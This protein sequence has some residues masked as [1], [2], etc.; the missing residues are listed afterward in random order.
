LK[1]EKGVRLVIDINWDL[2]PVSAA[3][4]LL[5]V[6]T[7]Y[8]QSNNSV[9]KTSF[10]HFDISFTE[11]NVIDIREAYIMSCRGGCTMGVHEG[12]VCRVGPN[13]VLSQTACRGEW[14]VWKTW[15]LLAD[16]L[17][18]YIPHMVYTFSTWSAK[19]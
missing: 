14:A 8:I 9:R 12:K 5:L 11:Q 19:I 10:S 15:T 1:K 2:C 6:A 4:S 16:F 3:C 7:S 17:Y 18:C 13:S